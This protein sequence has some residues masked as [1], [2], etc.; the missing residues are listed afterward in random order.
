VAEVLGLIQQAGLSRIA[1]V[2]EPP[3]GAND[4]R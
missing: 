2:A 1:F 4:A 3:H